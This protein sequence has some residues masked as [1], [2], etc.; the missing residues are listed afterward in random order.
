MKRWNCLSAIG[1]LGGVAGCAG[2]QAQ[3]ID[4]ANA[5]TPPALPPEININTVRPERLVLR[6][7]NFVSARISSNL[8]YPENFLQM[9]VLAR[10]YPKTRLLRVSSVDQS[11]G[12]VHNETALYNRRAGTLKL[13][14][15]EASEMGLVFKTTL[16]ARVS[17]ATLVRAAQANAAGFDELPKFGA[18]LKSRRTDETF[19][20]R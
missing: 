3:M 17:A 19:N 8:V 15:V 6:S 18:T 12:Y 10:D 7:P 1:L 4:G 5:A 2:P 9:G 11:C 20:A 14:R 16:Y 13:Y